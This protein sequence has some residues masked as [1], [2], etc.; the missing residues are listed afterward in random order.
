MPIGESEVS[1][2]GVKSPGD[3][4]PRGE[5]GLNGERESPLSD[6]DDE[7]GGEGALE[8]QE[9]SLLL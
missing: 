7:A 6:D 4:P 2:G 1:S 8:E 9:P 5:L 3:D